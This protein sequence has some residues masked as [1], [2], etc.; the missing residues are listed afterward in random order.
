MRITRTKALAG[1]SV[2]ALSAL[3]FT[4]T[5]HAQDVPDPE[6]C[7]VI[8]DE[9]EKQACLERLDAVDPL[10][11]SG[12]ADTLPEDAE[13]TQ[14]VSEDAIVITGSRIRRDNFTAT[15]PIQVINPEVALQEGDVETADILQQSP[16]AAG[17]TQ[18]TAALSSN[19]VTDGGPGAQT[20]SLRGLGAQ[21]TLVLVNGRRAGPAG[22]RGSVGP[23]DLNVIPSSLIGSVE[24]VK[25]G[26]SSIYG[27]DAIAGVVNLI[28]DTEFDGLEL[29]LFYSPTQEGGAD[30]FRASAAFGKTF[31][32]GHFQIGGDY[33]KRSALK[34][35]DRD[36]LACG[37]E[38]LF[39]RDG[40]QRVDVNDPR[41]GEPLCGNTYGPVIQVYDYPFLV[42]ATGEGYV[43]PFFNPNGGQI[44]FNDPG[45]RL[46]EFLSPVGAFAPGYYETSIPIAAFRNGSVPFE[47]YQNAYAL[48]NDESPR[49]LEVDVYPEIERYTAYADG[50]YE[51][52]DGIEFFAEGLYNKRK[53]N[54]TDERQLFFFQYTRDAFITPQ[55]L[56]DPAIGDPVTSIRGD[57]LVRPIVPFLYDSSQE[58]DYYRGVAGLRGDF[59][60]FGMDGWWENAFYDFHVQYSY[61]D[62]EYRNDQVAQDAVDLVEFRQQACNGRLT[63]YRGVPC[64]DIDF[65]DPR[66]QNGEFSPEE[67]AFLFFETVGKT[68]YSQINSELI[69]GNELTTLPAG[70]VGFVVGVQ[71]RRDEI[72]DVPDQAVQDGQNW[73]FTQA[74]ITAGSFTSYEAFGEIEVP[75]LAQAA[76]FQYVALSGAARVTNNEYERIDGLSYS[77]KGNFTY[78]LGVNWE[79][80]D[81]L[82]FRASY[83][84]SYR[85]PALF[86]A[87]LGRET[88][89][90]TPGDPCLNVLVPENPNPT[91]VSRCANEG[92]DPNF[93]RGGSSEI[94][95]IGGIEQDLNSETS[96]ALT[97]S[98]VLT[99]RDLL[100]RG[101]DLSLALDYIKIKVDDQIGQYGAGF[102]VAACYDPERPENNPFCDLFTRGQSIRN[103]SLLGQIE[104]VDNPFVNIAAQRNE[105]IDVSGRFTQDLEE[106]GRLSI[107]A[108]MSW[109]LTSE[110]IAI[111]GATPID[112]TGEVGQPDWIGDFNATYAL[113]NFSIN[114]GLDVIGGANDEEDI[115][116]SIGTGDVCFNSTL[117]SADGSGP[118]EACPIFK[119]EPTF[120]HSLSGTARVLDRFSVTLGVSNLFD[121]RPP[122]VSTV[123]SP[124]S[125]FGQA[126]AFASQYDYLGRRFF[127]N[128]RATF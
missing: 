119:L 107:N 110:T 121:T 66:I 101:A 56:G 125:T 3:L 115:I 42:G 75:V 112:N 2:A 86:E 81:L 73:G 104:F 116:A 74:Q 83:G 1:S 36:F 76:P 51:L 13:R 122:L 109:Q 57:F 35:G 52:A 98:A 97:L 123:V 19:F 4:G 127:A 90:A 78:K 21:R 102:I 85:A 23:F 9:E 68:T 91:Y 108:L 33:F 113:D 30:Q 71:A 61:S 80:N 79:V 64:V 46:D 54:N 11:Q 120:Y 8:A 44:Q 114:Y 47:Y 84:T 48:L 6:N 18:I 65:A 26:A 39:N 117:R 105:A 128:V 25:T 60:D 94:F 82:R 53:T 37:E 111:D 96:D 31:D 59:A 58:V 70:P 92:V 67:E 40:S 87:L 118:I 89:F 43:S 77:E 27:S 10:T 106:Y 103:P 38:Y 16:L 7:A 32:R 99:P 29:D 45:D 124:F 14:A 50:A 12:S 126:P 41:T 17:S 62:G 72:N 55:V 49:T 22:T 34:R 5:A 15:D 69:F 93:I 95:S 20:L 24:I 100:W 63:S 28:T 88:G